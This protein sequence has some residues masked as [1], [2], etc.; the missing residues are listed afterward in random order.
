MGKC[1][2]RCNGNGSYNVTLPCWT[3]E[4]NFRERTRTINKPQGSPEIKTQQIRFIWNEFGFERNKS[5]ITS[6]LLRTAEIVLYRVPQKKTKRQRHDFRKRRAS[7]SFLDVKNK[8]RG[9]GHR[10]EINAL[11]KNEPSESEHEYHFETL[12][13]LENQNNRAWQTQGNKDL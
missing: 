13:S 2:F 4:N 11:S 8:P 5:E 6:K 1:Y 3:P 9:I 12:W 7:Q 10:W